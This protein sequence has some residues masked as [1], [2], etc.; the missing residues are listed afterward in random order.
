VKFQIGQVFRYPQIQKPVPEIIDGLPNFFAA[1]LLP[2][3]KLAAMQKG[4]NPVTPVRSG[5]SR[6]RPVVLIASSP[7]LAGTRRTPWKDYLNPDK[8]HVRYFGDNKQPLPNGGL[9]PA[10]AAPGNK[11]LEQ[12]R[13]RHTAATSEFELRLGAAPFV[14]FERGEP[15]RVRFQGF[16]VIERAEVVTQWDPGSERSFSNLMYDFGVLTLKSEGELFD[17]EWIVAR[18]T[19]TVSDTEC[20]ALAPESWKYWVAGGNES[21][22]LVRRRVVVP[23]VVKASA[24]A[25]IKGGREARTLQQIYDFFTPR[26]K[27]AFEAV[28]EL[29]AEDI[30]SQNGGRYR[31]G[32]ITRP[33]GDRGADF[34]GR[35]DVGVG[36][37][38]ARVTVLGQAKCVPP[39]S[40]TGGVAIAR[41]AARLRRGWIG[42]FVTTGRL[43]EHAQEEIAEDEYPLIMVNGLGVAESVHRMMAAEGKRITDASVRRFLDNALAAYPGRIHHRLPSE[44]LVDDG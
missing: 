44:L 33:S 42:I 7:H 43:S 16:G 27:H 22:K 12:E 24:Q 13:V 39:G 25:P 21:L 37:S 5:T 26:N 3:G 36:F 15:G 11:I 1:S 10:E 17:W 14:F 19:P 32:W 41:T 2:G 9:R 28:A 38:T 30:L 29:V 35:L 40:A 23:P 34:Y 4:I 18:A 8:G 6:R 31:L 20:L